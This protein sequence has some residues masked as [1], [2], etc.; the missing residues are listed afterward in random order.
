MGQ[1]V[2]AGNP[3]VEI[4][5]RASS[6]AR[7]I[8][9]R[10]SGLDGRVTLTYPRHV[11]S[12]EALEFAHAKAD[13]LRTRL[14][15]TP[16][17]VFVAVG[18][19]IPVEGREMRITAGVGRSLSIRDGTICLPQAA[20]ATGVVVE[21]WLKALARERLVAASDRYAAKLGRQYA[22][23]TLR[24][25]R[26]RWGSCSS[27][28]G[29]MYSWRLIMAPPEVLDYVAAHEVAHLQ[30]MHHGPEFWDLVAEL[31]PDYQAPRRWLRDNG[32]GLHRFRFRD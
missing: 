7:R 2:I 14:D 24:D 27:L 26:S 23:L 4:T 32:S 19:A 6:R 22:R 3:P 31:C 8:S 28:G 16:E 15:K 21:A 10:I 20:T 11:A 13:W 25:T 30:E 9:L 29:L 1:H 5:L 18:A 12:D 17:A